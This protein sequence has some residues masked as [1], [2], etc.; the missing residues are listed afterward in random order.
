MFDDW[1]VRETRDVTFL[2][3]PSPAGRRV[4]VVEIDAS[5]HAAAK[6][7]KFKLV[8][9]AVAF[10]GLVVAD[11][12]DMLA[13]SRGGGS[14][15]GATNTSIPLHAVGCGCGYCGSSMQ[16]GYWRLQS[17]TGRTHQLQ[18]TID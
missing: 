8:C 17:H 14:G 3:D 9:T 4:K 5:T 11:I 6:N 15:G 1:Y 16:I 7:F 18:V 13:S 10:L 12:D 2:L